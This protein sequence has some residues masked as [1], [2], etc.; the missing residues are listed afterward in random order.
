MSSL[1]KQPS[2]IALLWFSKYLVLV[3][4]HTNTFDGL[5]MRIIA[6]DNYL[7]ANMLSKGR[8]NSI[9]MKQLTRPLPARHYA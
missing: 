2:H 6:A 4:P 5:Q 3:A 1:Y 7:T 8:V 9:I